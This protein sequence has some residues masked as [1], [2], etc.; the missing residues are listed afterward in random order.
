MIYYQNGSVNT[1]IDSETL[2]QG[3]FTALEKLGKKDHVL[4][5]PPDQTRIHSRAGE[6]TNLVYKYY[7][8]KLT[9]I[10]PALGT[11]TPMTKDQLADMFGDVPLELFRVHDWR[12]DVLT[13]GIVSEEEVAEITSGVLRYSWPAQLNKMI[14]N[15]RH[16]L[17]IS[18]GQVVPHEVIGMAN[19]NKNLF[20]GTG[21]SEGI[22]KSHFIAAV[23]GLENLMGIADNPVRR[24]LNYAEK[25]FISHLPV[26]YIQTVIGWDESDNLVIRGLYIGDD[27]EVFYLAS[28]LSLKVNFTMFDKPLKKVVVYLDPVEYKSTW[29]GNKSIYRTRMAMADNG[30]IIVLAPGLKEFG[31][32]KEID[33]LIRKYG[34]RGT[35]S[36]L[37]EVK[38]N[39]ELRQNLAAAAHL[40]HGS[41]EGRFS[42]TYC[43]GHVSKEEIESV[44]FKYYDLSEAIKK[45]NPSVMKDGY[46]TTPEG[47]E[48][49]Y[50]SNPSLGLWSSREK[51]ENK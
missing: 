34:Y 20:V 4:A 28:E 15:G 40:I 2:Q 32:D 23:Y 30:E 13:L 12:K 37:E 1:I 16:D 47:E 3:L 26:L 17:I 19:F 8:E 14:Y 46:N 18:I 25:K 50:I 27:I 45:Y 33:R 42:V 31:E 39:E 6:I 22:N 36:T 51:I 35:P 48:V 38:N 24:I 10:L 43:P 49:F 7:R 44:N 11:H 9:D 29:L 21:G 5:V 41:S